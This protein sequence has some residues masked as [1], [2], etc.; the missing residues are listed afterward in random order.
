MS[1]FPTK[2]VKKIT[3]CAL[4]KVIMAEAVGVPMK[5]LNQWIEDEAL[6]RINRK[7]FFKPFE[8][9]ILIDFCGG[10]ENIRHEVI[11]RYIS[12]LNRRQF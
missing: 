10:V 4:P 2:K 8:V 5:Q 7:K 11:D 6:F 1:N 3:I 9:Q 12:S